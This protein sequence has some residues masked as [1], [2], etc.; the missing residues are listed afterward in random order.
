MTLLVAFTLVLKYV[1]LALLL[2]VLIATQVIRL[3]D[4]WFDVPHKAAQHRVLVAEQGV[5]LLSHGL[6]AW[7]VDPP[8]TELSL[9]ITARRP[10]DVYVVRPQGLEELVQ[11]STTSHAVFTLRNTW[12]LREIVELP[13]K[14][15]WVVVVDNR[16]WRAVTVNVTVHGTC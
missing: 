4:V 10:V 6:L 11:T 15:P 13:D 5:L 12:T 16:S 1:A 7:S 3:V 9:D 14:G 8:G 2:A